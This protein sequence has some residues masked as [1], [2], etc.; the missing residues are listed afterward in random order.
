MPLTPLS[1][2]ALRP[3]DVAPEVPLDTTADVEDLDGPL[4]QSRAAEALR[5][6]LGLRG[7]GYN[8]YVMGPPG[9]G[10]HELVL[11]ALAR[12]GADA[13]T[14]SDWVY[15]NDF[16]D[17]RRPRAVELPAGRGSELRRDIDRLIE[18]LR[19]AIPAAFES[20][21]YR[22]R[23]QVLDK[24][25]EGEREGAIEAVRKHATEKGVALL[26]TPMGF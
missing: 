21:E 20:T 3:A 9:G 8:V 7:D 2:E 13:A 25:L 17:P 6:A 26:R 11:R 16:S 18:E 15:L 12:A 19:A 10:K 23:L 14:P 5:F 1:P 4:G 24:Q 22:A